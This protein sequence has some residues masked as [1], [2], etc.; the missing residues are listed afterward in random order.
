MFAGAAVT[1]QEVDEVDRRG[2][3]LV[4]VGVR[5]RGDELGQKWGR[6]DTTFQYRNGPK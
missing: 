6:S 5:H 3:V 2:A 1:G 4:K